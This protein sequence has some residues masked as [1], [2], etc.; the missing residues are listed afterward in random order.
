MLSL[1]MSDVLDVQLGPRPPCRR[2]GR[3]SPARPSCRTAPGSRPRSRC[4]AGCRR[5]P[6]RW[7]GRRPGRH[8]TGPRS[9]PS[10]AAAPMAPRTPS[11]L[12][13]VT[14]MRWPGRV[15]SRSVMPSSAWSVRSSSG[16]MVSLM[17]GQY[18]LKP[19]R[20]PPMRA[21]LASPAADR[22]ERHVCVVLA[23]PV[24]LGVLA[25]AGTGQPSGLVVV[26]TKEDV[27]AG[28]LDDVDGDGGDVAVG[29]AEF[30]RL[31]LID[32]EVDDALGAAWVFSCW[33]TG[34]RS[35]RHRCWCRRRCRS[36]P[37]YR[38]LLGDALGDQVHERDVL[39]ERDVADLLA[40]AAA[41][42]GTARRDSR[43]RGRRSRPGAGRPGCILRHDRRRG[44][45]EQA[46]NRQHRQARAR[47]A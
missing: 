30:R 37:D 36:T 45:H 4:T 34:E 2:A 7:T 40:D 32:L 39:T 11:S 44:E 31:R 5:C 18:S 9:R 38:D 35:P 24:V 13:A 25:H 19:S 21:A 23:V 6:S 22:L 3:S 17:I 8:R 47:H 43:G 12:M 1:L 20:M 28:R 33:R 15:G 42:D 26:G 10:V 14:M 27:L 29:G 41:L 46:G 16:R